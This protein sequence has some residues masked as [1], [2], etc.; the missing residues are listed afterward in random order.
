VV[1]SE[2]PPY[3]YVCVERPVV[4]VEPCTHDT[5]E[6]RLTHRYVGREAEPNILVRVRPE[7]WLSVDYR[8]AFPQ[9]GA[10]GAQ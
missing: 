1:Q 3:Q 2:K 10:A 9:A 8:K 6:R 4:A 7:R 5:A